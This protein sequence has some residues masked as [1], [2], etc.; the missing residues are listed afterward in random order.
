MRLVV[1]GAILAVATGGTACTGLGGATTSPR[2]TVT[3]ATGGVSSDAAFYIGVEKGYF[4]E[5]GIDVQLVPFK[6]PADVTAAV[7]TGNVDV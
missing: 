3:V 1:I 6:V 5:Q 2:A 7:A 4:A